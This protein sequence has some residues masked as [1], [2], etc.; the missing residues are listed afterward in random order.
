MKSVVDETEHAVA[1]SR[2][3]HQAVLD[4]QKPLPGEWPSH[5]DVSVEVTDETG[6]TRKIS[7]SEYLAQVGN[8]NRGGT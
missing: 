3:G 1:Q 6:T 4:K 8:N 2:A 7:F 5:P